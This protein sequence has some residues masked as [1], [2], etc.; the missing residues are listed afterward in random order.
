MEALCEK[1][2]QHIG[3]A[4]VRQKPSNASCIGAAVHGKRDKNPRFSNA[5]ITMGV[6]TAK[7]KEVYNSVNMRSF[8][9]VLN[10]LHSFIGVT[11]VGAGGGVKAPL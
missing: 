9:E 1:R 5:F 8:V 2:A 4:K 3:V 7:K 11:W 10:L 6:K